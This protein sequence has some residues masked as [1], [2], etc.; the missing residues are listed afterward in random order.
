MKIRN[1]FVSN[2]SS[3]SFV[4]IGNPIAISELKPE[5]IGRGIIVIGRTLADGEDVI[6]IVDKPMLKFIQEHEKYFYKAFV[7]AREFEDVDTTITKDFVGKK[8]FSI[9]ADQNGSYD[10]NNLK[11]NYEG[12]INEN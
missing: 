4:I 5:D 8:M 3:S 7:D 12:E 6:K 2:S 10:I 9:T 11:E 1:G